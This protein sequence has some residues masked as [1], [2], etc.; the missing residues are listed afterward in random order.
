[1]DY[2][3]EETLTVLLLKLGELLPGLPAEDVAGSLLVDD[4]V[5][6][7]VQRGCSTLRPALKPNA[8]VPEKVLKARMQVEKSRTGMKWPNT[9]GKWDMDVNTKKISLWWRKSLSWKA[10]LLSKRRAGDIWGCR[11]HKTHI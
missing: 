6:S 4:C 9:F 2:N 11:H 8:E 10:S 5:S 7:A 3:L 1:M